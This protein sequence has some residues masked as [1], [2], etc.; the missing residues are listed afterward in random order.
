MATA[1]ALVPFNTFG[2]FGHWVT[3][4]VRRLYAH[5]VRAICMYRL[6]QDW[7]SE[8]TKSTQNTQLH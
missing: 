8:D 6:T 5:K 4:E 3:V 2:L 1:R 7:P